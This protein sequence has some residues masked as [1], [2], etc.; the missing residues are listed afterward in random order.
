MHTHV[1]ACAWLM[2][3]DICEPACEYVSMASYTYIPSL[4]KKWCSLLLRAASVGGELTPKTNEVKEDN[5]RLILTDP[6]E[7]Q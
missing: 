7:K 4:G 5:C 1:F 6:H 2:S 3:V